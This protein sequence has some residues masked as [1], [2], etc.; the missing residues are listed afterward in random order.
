MN[1]VAILSSIL[2]MQ[3]YS[4][5]L[6]NIIKMVN[7]GAFKELCICELF[8]KPNITPYDLKRLPRLIKEFIFV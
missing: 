1:C 2:K 8:V 4:P 3:F 6:S 7:T 5:G